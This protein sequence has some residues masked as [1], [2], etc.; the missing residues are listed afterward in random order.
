MDFHIYTTLRDWARRATPEDRLVNDLDA[1]YGKTFSDAYRMRSG[2]FMGQMLNERDWEKARRPYYNVWP[3]VVPML[4]R[5]N[6]DLDSALIRPAA[7]RPLR[8]LPQRS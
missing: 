5:L 3:A 4:T 1:F 6:L 8:S 2:Q 7:A